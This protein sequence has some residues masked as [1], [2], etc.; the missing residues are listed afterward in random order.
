MQA[1]LVLFGLASAAAALVDSAGALIVLRALMGLGGAMIMPATLSI[2]T[3]VF[4]PKERAKAV[5]IWAG[6]SGGGVA[7]MTFELLR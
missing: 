2:L 6:V 4:P 5:G 1:G 7:A 3:N